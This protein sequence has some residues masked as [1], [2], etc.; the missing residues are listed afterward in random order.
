MTHLSEAGLLEILSKPFYSTTKTK[1]TITE[2][3]D[4]GPESRLQAKIRKYAKDRGYPCL[5]FPQTKAVM[6]FLPPGYL[7]IVLSLPY[8]FTIYFETKSKTGQLRKKQNL[9]IGMLEQLGHHV[10]Q[11]R[12]YKRFLEIMK[13]VEVRE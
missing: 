7:D 4:E 5:I 9:M 12:S 11:I 2:Q 8:C 3:A 6:K 1:T 13:N 10:Y